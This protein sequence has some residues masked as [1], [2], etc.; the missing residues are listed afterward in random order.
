MIS[1]SGVNMYLNNRDSLENRLYAK[2]YELFN[3]NKNHYYGNSI[4][5]EAK[6]QYLNK[7]YN[8]TLMLLDKLPSSVTI[9]SEKLL[10]QGLTLMELKR[11]DEAIEKLEQLQNINTYKP[12]QSINNWYLSLC[13]LKTGKNEQAIEQLEKITKT[14]SNFYDEAKKLLKKL[15]K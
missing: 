12:I 6:K 4:F 3:N 9:E 7:E 8:L 11:Y 14:N 13:Y 10:Y 1:F 15:K 2:Y 5:L